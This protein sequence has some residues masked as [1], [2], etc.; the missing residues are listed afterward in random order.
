M[1]K[2]NRWFGEK[3]ERK[4]GKCKMIENERLKNILS[5]NIGKV[6]ANQFNVKK[7]LGDYKSWNID[8]E[9]SKLFIDEREFDIEV[10]GTTSKVDNKWFDASCEKYIP[11]EFRGILSG[12]KDNM[13]RKGIE[14]LFPEKIELSTEY[15]GHVIASI[16]TAFADKNYCYFCGR[17]NE[18][19]IYV[20]I[21]NL[22]DEIFAPVNANTF[23]A[24]VTQILQV[25]SV[26]HRDMIK[27]F[28]LANQNTISETEEELQINF[29][30]EEKVICKIEN[31][32]LISMN[33]KFPGSVNGIDTMNE[34]N[35]TDES[36]AED[37][38]KI[39]ELKLDKWKKESGYDGDDVIIFLPEIMFDD[40]L[41]IFPIYKIK[42]NK[43]TLCSKLHVF[44]L[45]NDE[46]FIEEITDETAIENIENIDYR[47]IKYKELIKQFTN[48]YLILL[49]MK[50]EDEKEQE[51]KLEYLT[52]ATK[53]YV[54]M[55]EKKLS[56]NI[57]VVGEIDATENDDLADNSQGIDNV[58]EVNKK[59]KEDIN[60]L[61]PD[62]V[63]RWFEG[64]SENIK[65]DFEFNAPNKLRYI[66]DDTLKIAYEFIKKGN[67]QLKYEKKE[68]N[69]E[70]EL[71]I[72]SKIIGMCNF[73][74]NSTK[75][76]LLSL[77]NNCEINGKKLFIEKSAVYNVDDSTPLERVCKGCNFDKCPKLVAGYVLYL[78]N[79][80]M[81]QE[82][83]KDREEFRKENNV[84]D[85]FAFS[86][87]IEKGLKN[88]GEKT[89]NYASALVEKG[90]VDVNKTLYEGYV[91][92]NSLYSCEQYKSMNESI[93]SIEES[94]EKDSRYITR[95]VSMKE[96]SFCNTYPCRLSGCPFETAGY[97]Y[98]LKKSGQEYKIIEDRKY[99]EQHKDE[100]KKEV[101]EKKKNKILELGLKKDARN[102]II[103]NEYGNNIK[104]TI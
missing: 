56:E 40:F 97:I 38:W 37:G 86:W 27:S 89:Y 68:E 98:Y 59:Q 2:F 94:K 103:F 21:K 26:N 16:Y 80:N 72:I 23:A 41:M 9:L 69:K 11:E 15:T 81:L 55:L 57:D 87:N 29:P 45:D 61:S 88:V 33:I 95:N 10:I 25:F 52:T 101:I 30:N 31:E 53:A 64:N 51:G 7:Y 58:R 104:R 79:N 60:I 67:I 90:I 62:Q 48:I 28:A 96:I 70:G 17:S 76:I 43:A 1:L 19:E 4:G 47:N 49:N 65:Y 54:D 32:K 92:I 12:I 18:L 66:G 20:C 24:R 77:K 85:V 91:R 63:S 14:D 71:K 82:A 99:Y 78:R 6:F 75:E 102:A 83:L 93:E 35:N 36:L 46:C 42:D 3:Y 5:E 13:R 50:K 73:E 8:V 39:L 22:P 34:E 100:I 74:N 84:N 44:T